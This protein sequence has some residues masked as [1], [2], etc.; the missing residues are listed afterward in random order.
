MDKKQLNF[1]KTYFGCY[2]PIE[3]VK[4]LTSLGTMSI[5]P[6]DEF[7]NVFSGDAEQYFEIIPTEDD[8]VLSIITDEIIRNKLE[9]EII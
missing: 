1:I 2:T 9:K 3:G 4:V 5:V 8:K 6:A 7:W